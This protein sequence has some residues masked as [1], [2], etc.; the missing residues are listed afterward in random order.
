MFGFTAEELK[1]W[2]EIWKNMAQVVSSG[3]GIFLLYKW[4]YSRR[5]RGTDLLI[6]LDT[7]FKTK[8]MSDG[9]Q[10]IEDNRKW[11]KLRTEILREIIS[12]ANPL[13]SGSVS[14]NDANVE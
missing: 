7:Q 14:I 13:N 6:Q 1:T 2:S 4:I 12:E 10:L 5:D 8:E 9:R 11:A 3:C